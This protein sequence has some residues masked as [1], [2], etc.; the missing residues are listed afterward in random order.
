[1]R[2]R[3]GFWRGVV[4]VER[5]VEIVH[6]PQR[7]GTQAASAGVISNAAAIRPKLAP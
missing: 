5:G 2:G 1:M 3:S 7:L 6:G 4:H